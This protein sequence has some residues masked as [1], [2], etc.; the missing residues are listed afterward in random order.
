MN[1]R[2]LFA[3]I[4]LVL[5]SSL[6]AALTGEAN[7]T[8][9]GE[10]AIAATQTETA[11]PAFVRSSCGRRAAAAGDVLPADAEPVDPEP[12]DPINTTDPGCICP[13]AGAG[14]VYTGDNCKLQAGGLTCRGNCDWKNGAR[15]TTTPCGT[16]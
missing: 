1:R 14:W 16:P 8:L 12:Q 2:A 3:L 10:P 15:V 13:H 11:P 4:C 6:L 7:Q 9:A 5:A